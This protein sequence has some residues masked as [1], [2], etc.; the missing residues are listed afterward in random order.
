M[1]KTSLAG[2]PRRLRYPLQPMKLMVVLVQAIVVCQDDK[3]LSDQDERK[4]KEA[5]KYF[6]LSWSQQRMKLNPVLG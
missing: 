4:G 3:G 5:E 6:L 1:A 2:F